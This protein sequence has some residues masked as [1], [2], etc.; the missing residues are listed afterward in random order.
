MGIQD[1]DYMHNKPRPF[2]SGGQTQ[3]GKVTP[4]QLPRGATRQTKQTEKA[5]IGGVIIGAIG[6]LL[7]NNQDIFQADTHGL[8]E[9][10]AMTEGPEPRLNMPSG[11]YRSVENGFP[12]SGAVQWY[13]VA[14]SGP[15]LGLVRIM[16]VNNANGDKVVR[17]RDP[18][19]GPVAQVY[20]R[21]GEGA[22]I[23]LPAG[24]YRVS[25]GVGRNWHGI[26]RQF[27]P[28]GRYYSD[29]TLQTTNNTTNYVIGDN[30]GAR[31]IIAANRF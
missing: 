29:G 6:L 20:I 27:G 25:Y 4:T 16:D 30:H 5:I 23:R 17:L 19:D 22:E 11:P 9:I 7:L 1:R 3:R 14:A 2:W 28:T 26:T 31:R 21:K 10:R 12:P 8:G 15:P 24:N 18:F 13:R